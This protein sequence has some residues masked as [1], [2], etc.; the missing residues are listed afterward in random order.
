MNVTQ[1]KELEARRPRVV[2][3]LAWTVLI[4]IGGTVV[5]AV[6]GAILAVVANGP[7]VRNL[8]GWSFIGVLALVFIGLRSW[9][10]PIHQRPD[11]MSQWRRQ[12]PT[13]GE[14]EIRR[15]LQIVGETLV[16]RKAS[17]PKLSPDDRPDDVSRALGGDGMDVVGMAM[18]VE[19][20]YSLELPENPSEAPQNLG[21]LFAYVTRHTSCPSRSCASEGHDRTARG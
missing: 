13:H 9:L 15:F 6:V 3:W 21:E 17:I 14:Q 11:Q 19:R 12:F 20:E 10:N 7:D 4:A 16:L 18:A 1:P 5:G 8:L 2:R